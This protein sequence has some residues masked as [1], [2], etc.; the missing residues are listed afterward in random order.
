MRF[1]GIPSLPATPARDVDGRSWK[2]PGGDRAVQLMS[3]TGRRGRRSRPWPAC[4]PVRTGKRH[5]RRASPPEA[6]WTGSRLPATGWPVRGAGRLA[7]PRHFC[8]RCVGC[9]PGSG[10]SLLGPR[11]S[12]Q[13]AATGTG[14]ALSDERRAGPR[15]LLR[16]VRGGR[17][18]R[19]SAGFASS[20]PFPAL[21]SDPRN[22]PDLRRIGPR[23]GPS[24]AAEGR[25]HGQSPM[26]AT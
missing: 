3:S 21:R 12:G 19:G 14:D 2:W 16:I 13:A 4:M 15:S 10:S 11:L 22:R 20:P 9:L 6:G 24:R 5:C 8:N 25:L 26:N 1:R 7:G 23:N 17:E 18:A